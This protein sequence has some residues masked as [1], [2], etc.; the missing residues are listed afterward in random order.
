VLPNLALPPAR[1]LSLGRS[2]KELLMSDK[3]SDTSV[4]WEIDSDT[5]QKLEELQKHLRES[6][7]QLAEAF[8]NLAENFRRFSKGFPE[9]VGILASNGW[10]ISSCYTPLAAIYPLADLFR[11]GDVDEGDR[12]QCSHF[13]GIRPKIESDLTKRFPHRARIISKAF[14]AHDSGS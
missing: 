5:R 4:L 3:K 13:A 1:L 9:Q 10:F 7:E 12:Q 6:H 11:S 14:A 8:A 2:T